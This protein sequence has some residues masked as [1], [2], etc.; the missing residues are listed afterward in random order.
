[1]DLSK[2]F[3]RA[4]TYFICLIF[5]VCTSVLIG[6]IVG[7]EPILSILPGAATMKFNTAFLFF[8]CSIL[9]AMLYIEG[10]HNQIV[11]WIFTIWLIGIA[12]TTILEFYL[13]PLGIDELMVPDPYSDNNPGRM[14]LGTAVCFVLLAI[15]FWGVRFEGSLIRKGTHFLLFLI[16]L[17]AIVSLV[18]YI[19]MIPI[20]N[21][22]AFYQTM[23]VHTSL[24]FIIISIL[25]MLKLPDGTFTVLVKGGEAGS[26][27]WRMVLPFVV[28]LPIVLSYFLLL[29]LERGVIAISFG[30]VLYAALS[31]LISIIYVTII[32]S[33]LN[34]S[35]ISRI[36]LSQRLVAKNAEL[37][38]FK[39]ALD[40]VAIV[41]V[42]DRKGM[43]TYVNDSFCRLSKYAPEELIG[44]NHSILKS[45]A[46]S[47]EFYRNLWSTIGRGNIWVG[48]IKNK[49]KDG[50]F[51]WV[52]SAII[53]F[54]TKLGR[55]H[56]Y[57]AIR[58]DITKRKEAE[59]LLTSQYVKQLEQKNKELEQFV[60]IASHDLQEPLRTIAGFSDILYNNYYEKLDETGRKSFEFVQQAAGRMSDLIKG[61]LDYSR[62]GAKENLQLLDC[63]E[64]LADIQGD[65][66]SAMVESGAIIIVEELPSIRA[67]RTGIHALFQNLIANALKF[68]AKDRQPKIEI[69][70]VKID[71][72]WK[73]C[74]ADNGIGI[75]EGHK[76]RIFDIFQRLHVRSEYEG[77]GIGLSHCRK[78]VE[79]H[80]GDIWVES[81][82][83]KGSQFFFTISESIS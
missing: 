6:W 10:A 22:A 80:G 20:E 3:D 37:S 65:L 45:G 55:I 79:L 34:K 13:G 9:L 2:A 60:Y 75:A 17:F 72:Q 73:F 46:H 12:A 40:Q 47:R 42:T 39:E 36:D 18:A 68:H 54:K 66:H 4:E 41:A 77:T 24:F 59:E 64:L 56:E 35:E 44:S 61:L 50:S 81:E 78:I 1:M 76:Q 83:G 25:L 28:L 51:Y 31:I 19:L 63:N 33:R 67:Y 69:T 21:R 7:Y 23:A 38:Q 5:L 11:Y 71:R 8:L 58:Q 26:R 14:S 48:E 62:L 49:A 16:L 27:M 57:I 43:I 15:G 53:P 70:A 74:V 30:V 52:H 32:S 82:V 29:A